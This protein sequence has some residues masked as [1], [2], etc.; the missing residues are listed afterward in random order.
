MLDPYPFVFSIELLK[1][2]TGAR[3]LPRLPP[4]N[5]P[6]YGLGGGMSLYKQ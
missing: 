3:V 6:R 4:L 2:W 1:S 5:D